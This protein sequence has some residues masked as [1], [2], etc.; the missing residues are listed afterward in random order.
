MTDDQLE[1]EGD[2]QEVPATDV[3]EL[4]EDVDEPF[5]GQEDVEPLEPPAR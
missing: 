3:V 5:D 4:P 2:D 1:L